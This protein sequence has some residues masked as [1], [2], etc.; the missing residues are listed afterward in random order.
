MGKKIQLKN[1]R[2]EKKDFRI[3]SKRAAL[4]L[5]PFFGEL[6][7]EQAVH[8][9]RSSQSLFLPELQ[10]IIS[11]AFSPNLKLKKKKRR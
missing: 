9:Q 7:G 10:R 4:R 8:K 6:I 11:N 5:P 1:E 2:D 3:K